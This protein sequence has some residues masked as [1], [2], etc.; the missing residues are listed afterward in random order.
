MK[1]FTIYKLLQVGEFPHQVMILRGGVGG[2]LMCG[3]SLIS[4]NKVLTAG[5]CCDGQSSSRLAVRVGAHHLYEE[6]PGQMD[7]AVS[8]VHLHEN[9]DSWTIQNDICMLDLAE[10]ANF[11]NENI[12]A[13]DIPSAD[14][15]YENGQLCTVS[16]WGTTSEGGSLAKVLMKVELPVVSDAKCRDAYGQNDIADSMICAGTDEGGKD[17]CQ[18]DSGGPLMCGFGL[19]GIV[20]WGY[21]CAQPGFPGVY[22]QTSYFVS[23]INSHM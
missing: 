22:T 4:P 23:W 21:G 15:E 12:A 1:K 18:G 14:L 20:S 2:S 11:G 8:E 19:D 9:Y 13:I 16:G 3:G 10:D 6:D 5:H 17:S 7:I